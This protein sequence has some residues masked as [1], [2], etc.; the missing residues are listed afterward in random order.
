MCEAANK[1]ATGAA[2]TD[3]AAQAA[4]E[5]MRARLIGLVEDM[6]EISKA[7]LQGIDPEFQ[8]STTWGALS[9]AVASL[10]VASTA[11]EEGDADAATAATVNVRSEFE[12]ARPY[13]GEPCFES[14]D[15][16]RV[17]GLD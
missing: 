4:D 16:D 10:E 12:P 5:S 2:A 15:I 8:S 17:L 14:A 13:M 9:K 6:V 7:S 3:R 1:I 11:L